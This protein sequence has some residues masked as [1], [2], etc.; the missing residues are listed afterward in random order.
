[1]L[2]D[3][4]DNRTMVVGHKVASVPI[5]PDIA[6]WE[7]ETEAAFAQEF[8]DFREFRDSLWPQWLRR[9]LASVRRRADGVD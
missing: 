5:D 3:P 4:N 1:M 8:D 9:L 7:R 2:P 6:P